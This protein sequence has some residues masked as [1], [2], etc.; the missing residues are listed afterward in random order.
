VQ[1]D[2]PSAI[3][4]SSYSTFD[5]DRIEW[6]LAIPVG[7]EFHEPDRHAAQHIV[8]ALIPEITFASRPSA[9]SNASADVAVSQHWAIFLAVRYEVDGDRL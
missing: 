9:N 6:R 3:E 5:S 4:W 8:F 1:Y 7:V 2:N